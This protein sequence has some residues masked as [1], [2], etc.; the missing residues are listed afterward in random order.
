MAGRRSAFPREKTCFISERARVFFLKINFFFVRVLD[1]EEVKMII[2]IGIQ[3]YPESRRYQPKTLRKK[4][5][6]QL[7]CPVL[8]F[9]F[10]VPV[11]ATD[12]RIFVPIFCLK[13]CIICCFVHHA[14]NTCYVMETERRRKRRK[15]RGKE[16]ANERKV[17]DQIK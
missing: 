12:I 17:F 14:N 3:E 8:K 6:F 5:D 11:Q 10:C 16:I 7:S 1:H 4:N 9:I 15:R 2:I 13:N